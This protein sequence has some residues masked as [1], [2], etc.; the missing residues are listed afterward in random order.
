MVLWVFSEKDVLAGARD[1][2]I[3]KYGC[4]EEHKKLHTNLP[5]SGNDGKILKSRDG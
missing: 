5:L 4:I 3:S 2:N 1:F